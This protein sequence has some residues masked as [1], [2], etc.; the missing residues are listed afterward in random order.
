MSGQPFIVR[1]AAVLGAGVMG[2]QIAAHLVNANVRC[3][4]SSCPR[5][6]AIRTATCS[7]RST[8]CASSSPV[9][10]RSP[11]ARRRSDRQLRSAS[12]APE[13]MRPRDRGDFRAHGLE[14]RSLQE[15]LAASRRAHDLRQQYVGAVDQPPRRVFSGRGA[16]AVLRRSF[17]QSAALHAS[18]RAHSRSTEPS[19]RY[20]TTSETFSSPR[21]ARASSA[22]R[23]RRTSSRTASVFS[24]CSPRFITPSGSGS[25]STPSMR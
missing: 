12:G 14:N 22:R 18:G 2:A 3:C 5:R 19:R 20:S 13:G 4:C 23:T 11:L 25:G 21:S 1:K 17:L 16:P 8:T 7:A 15:S 6:K 24:R 10:W 9:R